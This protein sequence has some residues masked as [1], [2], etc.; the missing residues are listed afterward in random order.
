MIFKISRS[1]VRETTPNL[2]RSSLVGQKTKKNSQNNLFNF[3][4]LT[5]NSQ[6]FSRGH[7]SDESSS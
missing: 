7:S 1:F 2:T 5:E 3:T 4:A 6:T